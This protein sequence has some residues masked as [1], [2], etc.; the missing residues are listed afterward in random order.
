MSNIL[1][2]LSLPCLSVFVW[3]P[4][5]ASCLDCPRAR[6]STIMLLL[7]TIPAGGGAA[8]EDTRRRAA[9]DAWSRC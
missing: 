4:Q 9:D 5:G 8:D 3:S 2:A 7:M 1:F 6:R